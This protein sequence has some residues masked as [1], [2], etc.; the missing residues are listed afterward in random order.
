MGLKLRIL[1]LW[2]PEWFQRRGLDEL[3]HQTTSGLEKLLDDQDDGDLKTIRPSK[4]NKPSK[5]SFKIHIT[6]IATIHYP[7]KEI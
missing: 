5:K 3:A 1:S 7:F 2:T 4:I 6:F